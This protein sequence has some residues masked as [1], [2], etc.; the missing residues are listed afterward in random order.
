MSQQQKYTEAFK[1]GAVEMVLEQGMRQA[2]VAKRLGTS[3]KNVSRWVM[4]AE[5][6]KRTIPGEQSFEQLQKENQA[7]LKENK[8]LRMEREVLKKATAFFVKES[9]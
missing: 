2:E 7:L 6:E 5:K 9:R 4:A 3:A 8:R 1:S